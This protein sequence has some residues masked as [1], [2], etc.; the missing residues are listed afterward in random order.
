MAVSTNVVSYAQVVFDATWQLESSGMFLP[1]V[2]MS[3]SLLPLQCAQ[4]VEIQTL[5]K[6]TVG[7]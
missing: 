6:A 3:C 1:A 5:K 2:H 4:A 7:T